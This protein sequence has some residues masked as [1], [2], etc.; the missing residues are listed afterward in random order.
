MGASS[1][2]TYNNTKIDQE[3]LIIISD[4]SGLYNDFQDIITDLKHVKKQYNSGDYQ[5]AIDNIPEI[6][7]AINKRSKRVSLM[8][9]EGTI[10]KRC[11]KKLEKISYKLHYSLEKTR[12]EQLR[13]YKQENTDLRRKLSEIERD[14]FI[15]RNQLPPQNGSHILIQPSA[16]ELCREQFE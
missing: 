3:L 9:G 7:E 16:P 15:L 8:H 13:Q 11:L 10:L 6:I 12:V 1:S 2:L 14:Y 4:L 5:Y